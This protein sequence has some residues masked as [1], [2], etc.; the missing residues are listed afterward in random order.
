MRQAAA[1]HDHGAAI[2]Y[3]DAVLAQQPELPRRAEALVA[4]ALAGASKGATDSAELE[5]AC[6]AARAAGRLEDAVAVLIAL[7]R[8]EVGNADRF[9]AYL[10]VA[11]E[12]AATLPPGP[13]TTLA[14]YARG[15]R[16]C[17][18]GQSAAALALAAGEIERARAAGV[19]TAEALMLVWHGAARL[20]LGD[21][22]GLD[23]MRRAYAFLDRHAHPKAAV[24]AYNLAET[25]VA[26][27]W[28]DEAAAMYDEGSAWAQRLGQ[29][30]DEVWL[31][32]GIA[33]I[34][35]HQGDRPRALL[36][37]EEAAATEGD[38]FGAMLTIA[39]RGFLRAEVDDRV[40]DDAERLIAFGRRARNREFSLLGTA[41]RAWAAWLRGV[42]GADEA[43][44]AFLATWRTS[45]S[46]SQP[47]AGPPSSA[48]PPA[49]S[50]RARGERRCCTS[51]RAA[52]PRPPRSSPRSPA[53][54]C[55]TP[56]CGSLRSR[57]PRPRPRRT[58]PRRSGA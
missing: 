11:L 56:R 50:A 2:A 24:T 51:R 20:D 55:A 22:G 12:L 43:C 49:G 57:A 30:A 13:V 47:T 58:P 32:L 40:V 1:R 37:L 33:E 5:A 53:S 27:G 9:D 21:P 29:P 38:D 17:T 28:L 14:P 34:A 36:A 26:S 35:Y 39:R 25:L 16:L 6:D 42:D 15:Y 4:R 46:C 31:R 54:R 19:Q 52:T 45:A 23:D 8:F 18:T 48:T 44:D 3:A 10:G 41:L 7:T